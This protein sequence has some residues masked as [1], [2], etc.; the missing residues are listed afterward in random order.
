MTPQDLAQFNNAIQLAQSGQKQIAHENL[1]D[2]ARRNQDAN[3][4]MWLAFTAPNLDIA[5]LALNQA[6]SLEPNSPN[7]VS[8]QSWLAG[9]KA[10]QALPPMPTYQAVPVQPIYQQQPMPPQQTTWTPQQYQ[11]LATGH[12]PPEQATMPMQQPKKNN[13]QTV[14]LIGAAVIVVLVVLGALVNFVQKDTIQANATSTRAAQNSPEAIAKSVYSSKVRSVVIGDL[15]GIGQSAIVTYNG[16]TAFDNRNFIKTANSDFSSLA[17]KLFS[18]Q[19]DL[20]YIRVIEFA[21]FTDVKGNSSNEVAVQIGVSR[22]TSNSTNW[23]KANADRL[24]L[25]VEEF[26]VHQALQQA[27]LQIKAGL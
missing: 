21:D 16:P 14:L 1:K 13:N 19:P 4:L 9:E 2:L 11:Q 23:P 5:T 15:S 17:P 18:S 20:K 10:K 12:Y 6:T 25:I 26:R 7:L 27:W 3:L 22:A 24:D 8:A